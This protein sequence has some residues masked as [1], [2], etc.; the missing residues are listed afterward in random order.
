MNHPKT[1]IFVQKKLFDRLTTFRQLE[2]RICRLPDIERGDAF[3]VFAEAY[4]STVANLKAKQVWTETN[5]PYSLRTQLVVSNRDKGVDGLLE[6]QLGDYHAYQV[7]FRTGRPV[8]SWTE[9]STFIGLADRVPH[10]LIFTNSNDF[11]DEVKLRTGVYAITGNDLDKLTPQDFQIIRARLQ[12]TIIPHKRKPP[13]PHQIEAL[14]NILPALTTYDR[15]TVLMACGTGKTLVELWCA[16]RRQAENVLILVPSLALMSQ[17]LRVWVSETSYTSFGYLCVCSDP[18]VNRGKDEIIF[19][20]SD[21]TFPVTTDPTEVRRFLNKPFSGVK[22]VFSTYQSAKVVAAGMKG[23]RVQSFD[24]GIFDEAHKTAGHCQK[25]F[26]SALDDKHL[27]IKKRLFFTATPR[28]YNIH[29]HDKEGDTKLYYSMDVPEV[30][31]PVV[32]QLSFAKAV[33]RDIICDYKVLISV[34]TSREVT[35][36]LLKRGEVLIK[37][38]SVRARQVANQLALRRAVA[39][40]GVDKIFTFHR[41]VDSAASFTCDGPEGAVSHLPNFLTLHVNGSMPTS[42]R[43]SIM[44]EFRGTPKGLIS[45]AKC[46]TEG[47]DVPAVDLVAFLASKRSHVDIVQ[48]IGRAM[49]KDPLSGK[50]VGYIFL[51]LYVEKKEDETLEEALKRN[52]FDEVWDVLEALQEQDRVLAD[53]I[54]KMREKQGEVN[55]FDD[56]LFAQKVDFLAPEI[57]LKTL[58]KA[59]TIQCVEVLGELWDYFFGQLKKYK[60]Q[61]GHCNVTQRENFTLNRWV[62]TQRSRFKI[63]KLSAER[64][65]RLNSI[66]FDWNPFATVLQKRLAELREFKKRF[67]HSNVPFN[68]PENPALAEWVTEMRKR[69][70][71]NF[72]SD[73]DF[74]QNP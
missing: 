3:E 36:H 42:R 67:G 23:S 45:N 64:V 49:R 37:G 65:Q 5:I 6:T 61:H 56:A 32:H 12:G 55:G 31:G 40:Y 10:K 14:D 72:A 59:I 15:A 58:R 73:P 1:H 27:S 53:I 17:M 22:L 25:S 18:T 19:H 50:T 35:Q 4:V 2:K 13:L 20:S 33:E 43:E 7:K 29:K 47:V 24:L 62:G 30:Y 70:R 11:A 71:N 69:G 21:L 44:K 68:W 48:A 51:P 60:K 8:L 28:H 9:I 16:E 57:L 39:K 74:S 63:G 38:D 66:G 41:T 34:V 52:K 26:G 54:K 46:L